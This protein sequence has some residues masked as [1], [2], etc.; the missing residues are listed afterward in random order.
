MILKKGKWWYTEIMHINGNKR[1]QSYFLYTACQPQYSFEHYQRVKHKQEEK[2]DRQIKQ[3]MFPNERKLAQELRKSSESNAKVQN[4][5][6]L[7][8]VSNQTYATT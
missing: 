7:T 2:E 5:A 6:E 4:Y 1:Y 3:L 8:H